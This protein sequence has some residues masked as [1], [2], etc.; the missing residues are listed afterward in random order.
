MKQENLNVPSY[1]RS[2]EKVI[3]VYLYVYLYV[4]L[5]YIFMQLFASRQN[6]KSQKTFISFL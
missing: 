3:N 6:V 4:F 5:M 2:K 1:E